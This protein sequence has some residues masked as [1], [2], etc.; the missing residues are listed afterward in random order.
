VY[1]YTWSFFIAVVAR[2]VRHQF[3]KLAHVGAEP[4]YGSTFPLDIPIKSVIISSMFKSSITFWKT[5][6]IVLLA[7][8]VIQLVALNNAVNKL[9]DYSTELNKS[10]NETT[11]LQYKLERLTNYVK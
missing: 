3:C 4:T 7:M 5:L 10:R 11:N 2:L 9:E 8:C 1:I 6:A